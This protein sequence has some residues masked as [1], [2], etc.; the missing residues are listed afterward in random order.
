M[1]IRIQY[2]S[3]I[4]TITS[5]AFV[6]QVSGCLWRSVADFNLKSNVNWIRSYNTDFY[7]SDSSVQEQYVAAIYWATV[8]S[9]TVGYGDITP[10]NKYELAWCMMIMAVGVIIFSYV[11]GD[12]AS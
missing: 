6:L 8:T 9:L 4:L 1:N 11:L 2:Q 5:L 12:L 10:T 3:M 7:L